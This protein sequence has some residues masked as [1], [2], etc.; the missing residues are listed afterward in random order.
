MTILVASAQLS[1]SHT[2]KMLRIHDLV[3]KNKS[4]M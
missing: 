1:F 4:L 3:V 2:A